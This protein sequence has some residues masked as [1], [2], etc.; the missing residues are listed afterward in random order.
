[1]L[2]NKVLKREKVKSF[3][4]DHIK[5][6]NLKPYD[7]IYSEKQ[8]TELCSVSQLTVRQALR[9]LVLAGEVF[10]IQGKGTFVSDGVNATL[11]GKKN[12]DIELI[13]PFVLDK[14]L[15]KHRWGGAYVL[16]NF[17]K[18]ISNSKNIKLNVSDTGNIVDK[19]RQIIKSTLKSNSD[20]IVF[21]P[22][23]N[24]TQDELNQNV[25]ILVRTGKPFITIERRVNID[26][27][28]VFEDE[29]FGAYLAAKHLISSGHRKIA[30]ISFSNSL[31]DFREMGY[32]KALI[33]SGLTVDKNLIYLQ[34]PRV[35]DGKY[36]WVWENLSRDALN[37][38]LGG[39]KFT[40]IFTVNDPAAFKAI[41]I[42]KKKGLRIPEDIAV[43]GYDNAEESIE[44]DL[45]TIDRPFG[46]MGKWAAKVIIDMLKKGKH[47][48]TKIALKPRLIVRGST[49]RR[50]S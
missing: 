46:D 30:F 31:F 20:I 3:I 2:V 32:K 28:N 39:K 5:N 1:M 47:N 14:H 43:V 27:Y 4:R 19:E 8:L 29:F 42:I 17:L 33:D 10:R 21:M 40:A 41:D 16:T 6:S 9:E 12:I 25:E 23:Y 26:A 18:Y 48:A 38:L 37:D 7:P 24:E 34:N 45:T 35:S 22:I 50:I 49:K 11:I 15:S 13:V 36:E 44:Y